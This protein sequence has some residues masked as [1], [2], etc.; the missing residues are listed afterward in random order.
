MGWKSRKFPDKFMFVMIEQ[1]N[2][3]GPTI[4][5]YTSDMAPEVDE[6]VPLFP[7]ILEGLL[8][9]IKSWFQSQAKDAV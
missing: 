4:F 6:L 1:Q 9:D 8:G 2:E 5:S 3:N 7:L